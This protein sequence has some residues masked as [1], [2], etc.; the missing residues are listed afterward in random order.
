MKSV[1]LI[2]L[3]MTTLSAWS[4]DTSTNPVVRKDTM[5]FGGFIS[6][7]FG[8]K[9]KAPKPQSGTALLPAI[10]YNPSVGFILGVNVASGFH[11]GDPATTS[12]SS[13]TATAYVTSKGILNLQLRHNVYTK[14]NAFLI[15]GNIQITKMLVLD[16]GLGPGSGK[17][18][19][20]S[21]L[22]P[23]KFN[24]IR[25]NEKLYKRVSKNV[26]V[27]AG[28]ALNYHFDINDETKEAD[29]TRATPHY[30]YS[31]YYDFNPKTYVLSGVFL[32]AQY[33]TRDHLNRAY[34]GLYADFTIRLNPTWMGST[35]KSIQAMTE[36]R[37]YFSLS[38]INPEHVLAF[39]HLGTYRFRGDLPYLDLPATATDMF[40]R[41]G[42]AYTIGRFRGPS[43]FYLE[44]EYRFPITDNKFLSG[45]V[46]ANIETVSDGLNRNLFEAYEPAGGA[47]IRILFNKKTRT[48]LCIDY[49][50]GK[51]GSKGLFFGLNEVF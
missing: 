34:K 5:D 22:F 27:G 7:T 15:Q 25:V 47:G 4:Q 37:K 9:Q 26:L 13:G 43:F 41:S 40:N 3:S 50:F 14:N 2:L 28:L 24:E 36:F 23:I 31:K 35:K 17:E 44:S 10:G 32:N 20:D 1:L 42:R 11:L 12:L 29:T 6:K 33:T 21:L 19:I 51:Y 8:K 30:T 46:F 16:Y 49:A 45:V 18:R 48:N 39:W 38:K